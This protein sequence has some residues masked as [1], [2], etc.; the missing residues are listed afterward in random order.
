LKGPKPKTAFERL[1]S[2]IF[3]D[4]GCWTVSGYVGPGMY[5]TITVTRDGVRSRPNAHRAVYLELVGAIP[6]DH[7]VD[8]LCRNKRCVN[9]DHLE[10][11][12]RAENLRRGAHWWE[13]GY[14]NPRLRKA[15]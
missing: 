7:D 9:P 8:H 12:P 5:P 6:G 2:K 14:A 10:A 11:V 3:Y 4:H 1:A 13:L 15:A